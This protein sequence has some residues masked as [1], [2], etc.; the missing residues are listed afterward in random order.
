MLDFFIKVFFFGGIFTTS[1]YCFITY[2]SRG[3]DKLFLGYGLFTLT[4]SFLFFARRVLPQFI[5]GDANPWPDSLSLVFINCAVGCGLY[6]FLIFF[7]IKRKQRAFGFF[8]VAFIAVTAVMLTT[9]AL[10]LAGL[11]KPP[12]IFYYIFVGAFTISGLVYVIRAIVLRQAAYR[13]NKRL[14]IYLGCVFLFLLALS[15]LNVFVPLIAFYL[16][17]PGLYALLVFFYFLH[18]SKLNLDY[19]E[20]VGLKTELE[21]KVRIR[22]EQV[23]DLHRKKQRFFLTVTHETKTPLTLVAGCLD[24]YMESAPPH[25]DLDL[26][27]RTLAALRT[28]LSNHLDFE[29]LLSDTEHFDHDQT[30]DLVRLLKEKAA[31]FQPLALKK[32]LALETSLPE[33]LSIAADPAA[34]D[35]VIN[36]LLD[37]AVKYTQPGGRVAVALGKKGATVILSVRDTG[38]GISPELREHMFDPFSQGSHKGGHVQG[39]GMGLA[40]V[41]Q[42]VD[43]LG[44]EIGIKS[45]PPQK[46]G[47][48]VTEIEVA[49][50]GM[51][52][53]KKRALAAGPAFTVSEPE[54]TIAPA[55]RISPAAGVGHDPYL[56]TVLLV[57][58]NADLL[59][60]LISS[61]GRLFNAYGASDGRAALDRIDALP[62]PD[63]IVSDIMMEGMD[64]YAFFAAL[65]ALPRYRDVPFIFL[66][67][68]SSPLEKLKSLSGGA[69]DFITKPLA[70]VA[71]LEAKIASLLELLKRRSAQTKGDMFDKLSRV[72]AE[73]RSDLPRR[74]HVFRENLAAF[75]LTDQERRIVECLRKGMQ[76]KEISARLGSATRTVD[77]H[78][79]NIFRKTGSQN[80][81]EL[82]NRLLSPR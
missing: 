12:F 70:S 66:T 16:I 35:Q 14:L 19:R 22:T 13:L 77:N 61:L 26:M 57:E 17:I 3:R 18:G 33:A 54:D 41:R 31:L 15:I 2:F 10:F 20:L 71:E 78:L 42:I 48:W 59:Q 43:G 53:D 25:P 30:T 29:K 65:Q 39:I 67:A 37:N 55:G 34:L 49:F 7:G 45:R 50:P 72:I 63:V 68:V 46:S 6:Y 73:E 5:P 44:G 51:L 69:I 4:S 64:G 11:E 38:I 27:K 36:N 79:Y 40:I 24:R 76:N 21:G 56:A 82:L 62:K 1:L 74:E 60:F 47:S 8:L 32:G 9:L 75:G 81:V 80:R 58:D 28:N 23:E 52:A